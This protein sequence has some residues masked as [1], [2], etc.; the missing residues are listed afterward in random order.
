MMSTKELPAWAG[1]VSISVLSLLACVEK[2]NVVMNTISIERDWVSPSITRPV[3][4]SLIYGRSSLLLKAMNMIFKVMSYLLYLTVSSLDSLLELNSQM[5]RI[6]LFCKLV[7]PL[8]IALIDGFSTKLAIS[9]TFGMTCISAGIEYF[10]IAKVRLRM[11][12]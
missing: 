7:G 3:R 6:D 12:R 9:V 10:A 4:R 1:V 2:L 11:S 5:R 8:A